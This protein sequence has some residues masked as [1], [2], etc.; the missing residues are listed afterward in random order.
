MNHF[1]FSKSN[2]APVLAK[3]ND[4]KKEF[5]Y[6]FIKSLRSISDWKATSLE[7]LFK[8]L[9]EAAGIKAGE[10]QLPLRLMLV[11][12]KFGPPVFEIAEVLGKEETVTRIEYALQQMP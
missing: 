9:A 8:Q 4:A 12:G 5:F 7:A 2:F 1:A 6:G 11:G 10:L 3:W